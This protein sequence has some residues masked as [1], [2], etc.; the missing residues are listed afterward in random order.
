MKKST[1][2]NSRPLLRN[3]TIPVHRP[4]VIFSAKAGGWVR[5]KSKQYKAIRRRCRTLGSSRLCRNESIF[6]ALKSGV[7]SAKAS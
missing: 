6:W 5:V 2:F 1:K 7:G 4:T 3:V